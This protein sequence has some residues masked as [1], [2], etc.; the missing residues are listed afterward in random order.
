MIP[1]APL[2]AMLSMPP[3]AVRLPSVPAV[4]GP[5]YSKE[6]VRLFQ[7]HCQSCHH[8]GD[9]APF[10]LTNYQDAKANAAKIK[11]KTQAREMPPWKPG[12]D[13]GGFKDTQLRTLTEGE[14]DMLARWVDN[15]A[16]LGDPADQPQLIDFSGGWALGSPNLE[17]GS[18]EPYTPPADHDEYRCF[19]L[20]SNLTSDKYVSAIDIKPGN[21]EEVH[22]VIVFIDTL[23]DSQKLDEES[24]GPGYTC[25]GGPGFNLPG[26]LG[27]WAPGARPFELPD[28]V[29][30]ALPA[31]SRI[32][33]QV[34]YHVHTGTL[35]PDRTKIPN[36]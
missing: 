15:G 17:L 13:C 22:H 3:R 28:E 4:S 2:V 26:T 30:M 9:I 29:G 36:H 18:P 8:P 23:G 33:L 20:P 32:V 10:A 5:T 6:I 14:I 7:T 21:R 31:N 12:T 27:G 35:K 16:P 25:F 1:I 34:H 19:T 24:A 11:L